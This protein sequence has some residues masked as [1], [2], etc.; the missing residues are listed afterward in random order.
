M[1][2]KQLTRK[3]K[4]AISDKKYREEHKCIVSCECGCKMSNYSMSKHLKSNKHVMMMA[5]ATEKSV[6]DTIVARRV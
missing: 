1:E 3:E 5:G 6:K 2:N 4:K